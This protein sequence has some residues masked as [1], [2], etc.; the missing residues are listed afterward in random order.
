VPSQLQLLPPESAW[1]VPL[2]TVGLVFTV[3]VTL[4]VVRLLRGLADPDELRSRV[5]SLESDVE[6]LRDRQSEQT[7]E[8]EPNPD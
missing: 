6:R 1:L 8:S 4:V 7:D 2:L 5:E 3:L